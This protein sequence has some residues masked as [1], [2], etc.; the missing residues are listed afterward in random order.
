MRKASTNE[1]VQFPAPDV[2]TKVI[3][4][5]TDGWDAISP[6]ADMDPK[7][8]PILDNWV[9]RPGYV[10]LRPGYQGWSVRNTGVPVETLMVYDNATTET[11]FAASG[12]DIID[13]STAGVATIVNSGFSSARFEWIMF[14][15][16]NGTPVLQAVNGNDIII[17]W[18]G[19]IWS[20]P[21]ITGLPAPYT[22]QDFFNIHAQKRRIWYILKNSTQVV[23][24]PTDAITGPIAGSQ[25]LGALW[26]KG[27]HLIEMGS[28][29]IDGSQ[30]PTDYV[31]FFSSQG[32]FTVY[33]GNDPTNANDWTLKGTFD[34]APPIGKRCTTRMGSDLM[35]L[36]LQ[37][38]LPISQTLPFD[39]SADRS[40]ALTT[41][42]Q[43]AMA[44]SAQT[45]SGNFGWELKTFPAAT[46]II[47][48]VPVSENSEA[49]QYVQNALT[50]AWCRF[51]GWNANTFQIYQNNLYFGDNDGN[52]QQAYSAGTDG[53]LPIIADMQVAFNWFEDPG[54]LKRMTMLQPLLTVLGGT[55][56]PT[57]GV[58]VDFSTNAIT[59]TVSELDVSSLWDSALWD[60]N[61]WT[62]TSF[63]Q[64]WVSVNALGHALAIR[65]KIT[66]A[67]ENDAGTFDFAVFDAGRFGL[68]GSGAPVLQVNA[69]NTIVEMG[70]FI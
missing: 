57:I 70:G 28:W 60:S 8:A 15:P 4:S 52:V 16:G 41:R 5:P 10:E 44:R 40:V 25:D 19:T 65:M 66:S 7:R 9:P 2:R 12:G 21:A 36:T 37:G 54:R 67:V 22:N 63:F 11:M 31:V 38:V 50:G 55:L 48:N 39:P 18:N 61:T 64:P 34:I 68:G 14:T 29:T 20:N 62:T 24:M 56:T 43:N 49:V 58:D 1:K 35:I 6:L 27:G 42:I 46:L 69:F 23:F 3:P 30:G 59:S 33:A 13:V 45:S 51:T 47:L 53:G 26:N 17:Q 32:Q